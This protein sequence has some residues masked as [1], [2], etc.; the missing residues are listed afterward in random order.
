MRAPRTRAPQ[1]A[2]RKG[3]AL[4]RRHGSLPFCALSRC[5][6]ATSHRRDPLAAAPHLVPG[7]AFGDVTQHDLTHSSSFQY[8]LA[9]GIIT[10]ALVT[11]LLVGYVFGL[12]N[13]SAFTE[14]RAAC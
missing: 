5:R 10:F 3:T 6:W 9:M 4:T 13:I 12:F 7:L 8:L 2:G 14:V 1:A 11:A